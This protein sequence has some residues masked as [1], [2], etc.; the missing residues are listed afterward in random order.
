VTLQRPD[1]LHVVTLG[2]GPASEFYHDG[3]AV[4]AYAP[5]ENLVAVAEARPRLVPVRRKLGQCL[6]RG[7][8]QSVSAVDRVL[9][10]EAERLAG[11]MTRSRVVQHA[12]AAW[13]RRR[14]QVRLGR[15][16]ERYYRSLTASERRE[17]EE[18]ASLAD[19]TV[20]HG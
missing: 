2:D 18:W 7:Q 11:P 8:G 3:R 15:G 19:E 1:K 13:V 4:T 16:V 6:V 10:R 20:R 14:G 17:D 5:A 9:L 12:L